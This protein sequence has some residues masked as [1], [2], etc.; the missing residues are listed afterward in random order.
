MGTVE[1]ME[2]L[3]L[4]FREAVGDCNNC[5]LG[6]KAIVLNLKNYNYEQR[7]SLQR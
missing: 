5:L 1:A 3:V 7:I 6:L 2:G 4:V